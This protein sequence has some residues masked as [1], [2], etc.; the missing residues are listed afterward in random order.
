MHCHTNLFDV[1]DPELVGTDL[2]VGLGRGD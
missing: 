1:L 2:A